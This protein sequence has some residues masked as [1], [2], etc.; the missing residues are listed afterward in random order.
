MSYGG[1]RRFRVFP[2]LVIALFL[3]GCPKRT[4]TTA[5]TASAPAAP[6]PA[7]LPPPPPAPTRPEPVVAQA[8]PTQE[9]AAPAPA[10]EPLPPGPPPPKEFTA[11]EALKDIHFDFDKH[12]LRPDDANVL[13][14][15]VGW[16]KANPDYLV[17]I[18]GHC[19]ERG[20]SEYN[21]A[22]GER[23]AKATMSYL[24]AQ[25]IETGRLTLLSYG[26]ERPLCTEKNETCWSQ[27]RRAHFLVKAR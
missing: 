27:N 16:L 5:V 11:V 17:L 25:G 22:L 18:E 2:L 4:V 21:L 9:P 14:D 8:A 24:V 15:N 7:V 13:D 3:V 26:K 10:E 19:D 23:R 20:T 12:D 1:Q 6:A